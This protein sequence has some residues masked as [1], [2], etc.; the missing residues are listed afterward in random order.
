[1]G[2]RYQA[3]RAQLPAL[4]PP[5][6]ALVESNPAIKLLQADTGRNILR[7]LIDYV[8]PRP[9]PG[10]AGL[11]VEMVGRLQNIMVLADGV[12]QGGK[13]FAKDGSGGGI[14]TKNIRY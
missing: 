8:V 1:M 6:S 13:S 9:A 12:P 4:F 11:A 10:R 5:F 14:H 2:S 7:S 3:S